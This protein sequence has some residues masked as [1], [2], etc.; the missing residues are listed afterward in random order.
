DQAVTMESDKFTPGHAASCADGA[1]ARCTQPVAYC[2]R[3][4]DDPEAFELADDA[5][6]APSRVFMGKTDRQHSHIA[7]DRPA[8]TSAVVRPPPRDQ[9]LM[10]SKQ[11]RRR[12]EERGPAVAR[13]QSTDGG[14]E[15]PVDGRD[16]W[17]TRTTPKNRE[18]VA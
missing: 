3:R 11:C 13:E 12:D 8:P 16:R 6:V 15:E 7:S 5:L 9:P 1:K 4:N 17:P 2:R 10:P 18:L 14:Q